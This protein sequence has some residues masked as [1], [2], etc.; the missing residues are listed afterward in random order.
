M[1]AIEE[2][3]KALVELHRLELEQLVDE[4]LEAELARLV[5]ERIQ[6]RNGNGNG[7]VSPDIVSGDSVVAVRTCSGPCGRTLP[8][9][10]FEKGRSKCREC[11]R[12]EHR[13]RQR[14]VEATAPEELPRPGGDLA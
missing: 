10:A 4:A 14:R 1:G 9:A 8:P 7:H 3:V 6:A 13:D 5:D 12:A 11:R 2:Q